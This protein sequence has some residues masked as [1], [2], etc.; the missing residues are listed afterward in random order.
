MLAL[1]RPEGAHRPTIRVLHSLSRFDETPAELMI[2]L[3]GGR[4]VALGTAKD[5]AVQEAREAILSEAPEDVARALSLEDLL[6]RMPT[7]STTGKSRVKRTAAQSAVK[8]LLC[9]G[10]LASVGRGKRGDPKRFYRLSASFR[11]NSYP[12]EGGDDPHSDAMVSAEAQG[13]P[14]ESIEL[15]THSQE[16]AGDGP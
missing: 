6:E 9:T 5:V 16:P 15:E 7:D 8:E 14:A 2:E 4:Y 10:A 3:V 13:V 1:R 12:K 11:R